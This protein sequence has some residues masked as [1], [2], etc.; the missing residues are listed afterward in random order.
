[1]SCENVIFLSEIMTGLKPLKQYKMHF[2]KYDKSDEP[3]DVY[4]NSFEEWKGWNEWSNGKDEFNR[5]YIFSLINFYP[6]KDTWLFGGI[7]KVV[8]HYPLKGPGRHYR[9]ELCDEYKKF[10]GRLKIKYAH[11]DRMV[12]NLMEKYFPQLILKEI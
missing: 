5:K 2:A 3:L 12:R 7:W 11:K 4:M 1:M 6:E 10:I 8:D 9:I